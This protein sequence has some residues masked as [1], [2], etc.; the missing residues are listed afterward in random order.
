M[1]ISIKNKLKKK[2]KY[3]KFFSKI[4]IIRYIHDKFGCI[5]MKDF[6]S[7]SYTMDRFNRWKSGRE[8]SM[9]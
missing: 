2:D 1:L 9:P 7:K 4:K 8:Q 6:C 3:Q 5:I